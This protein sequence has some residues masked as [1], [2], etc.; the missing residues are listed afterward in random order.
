MNWQH[1]K[2]AML[3]HRWTVAPDDWVHGIAAERNC[4]CGAYIA[5]IKW[6]P[7]PPMP[8]CKPPKPEPMP[9]VRC[10]L[11]SITDA[12]KELERGEQVWN[13]T[14]LDD[15]IRS[16]EFFIKAARDSMASQSAD[17]PRPVIPQPKAGG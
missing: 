7:A 5:A 4:G 6:P 11:L 14:Q 13:V 9:Q 17:R 16:A 2:C 10:A 3:G 15:A 12:R 8:T 1:I